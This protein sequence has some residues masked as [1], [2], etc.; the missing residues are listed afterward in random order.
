MVP[1]H[2]ISVRMLASRCSIGIHYQSVPLY[3]MLWSTEMG[4]KGYINTDIMTKIYQKKIQN[5]EFGPSRKTISTSQQSTGIITSRLHSLHK[6]WTSLLCHLCRYKQGNNIN[7]ITFYYQAHKKKGAMLNMSSGRKGRGVGFGNC[8]ASSKE[9]ESGV[10]NAGKA[11]HER[12]FSAHLSFMTVK[13]EVAHAGS[14]ML[15]KNLKEVSHYQN[16]HI[17]CIFKKK[18]KKRKEEKCAR[19]VVVDMLLP[20]YRIKQRI[21]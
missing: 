8:L 3:V 15:V 10:S 1:S 12:N 20:E 7:T 5:N 21:L 17:T 9:W 14:T 19:M 4:Q 6:T 11:T 16:P 2:R 18:K 13:W